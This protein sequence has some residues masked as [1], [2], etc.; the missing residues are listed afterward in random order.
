MRDKTA[1]MKRYLTIFTAGILLSMG[2]SSRAQDI[3]FSQF[4]ENEIF[5]NPALT[6]VFSGD[7]KFGVDYRSQWGTIAVPFNT[8]MLAGETKILVN[9]D[10]GDYLSFGLAYTHDQAGT[11]NF[12]SNQ[13][14]PAIAFN[15]ALED[16]HNTYL[17]VGF[18]GGYISRNVDMSLMTF[19]S[20]Y[21]N[22]SYS[23][24]NP[25]GETYVY[26]GLHNY[27]VGA[28]VSLNSSL[29]LNS[30]FNYYIGAALYHINSPT[31]IFNGGSV[32]VKL[33]MK[34]E[35]NGGIHLPLSDQFSFTAHAN[36]SVQQPYQ[37]LI[38]GGL[39]T[40]KA[41]QVGL[42]SIF[43]FHFGLLVR[44]QDAIIPTFKFDYKNTSLGFSYDS[45]NS[46]L[47]NNAGAGTSATEITLYVRGNYKHSKNPRDPLQCPRFED[48]PNFGNSFR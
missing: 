13:I 15:K 45:N 43:A 38:F 48:D 3:H 36:L 31:E 1:K 16:E 26:K 37:E 35:L 6:G 14:Y 42:P 4:W 28:G 22:S 10:A 29:D 20:Q 33:P 21:V 27:D 9:R 5:H 18:T 17:S 39:F 44:Y 8:V 41:L 40:W 32:L 23:S 2:I 46:S 24:N 7:Y 30:R 19:S 47:S 34:W 11:I 25:S 12:A